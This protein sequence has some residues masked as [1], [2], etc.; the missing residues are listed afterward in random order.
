MVE[1]EESAQTVAPLHVGGRAPRQWRLLQKP[2]VESLMVSLAVVVLDVLPREKAQVVLTERDHTIETFLFD[3]P[4]ES[5]GV[6]VE[7]GTPRR[8]P[9]GRD[10]AAHQNVG[11]D[12]GV[13]GIPVVNEIARGPQET[14]NGISER[15]GHLLDPRATGVLVEPAICTRRVCSSIT[16]KNRYRLRPASVSTSTVKKSAAAR[17]VQCASKNVVPIEK[18]I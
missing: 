11:N 16:K 14:V 1:I 7:I 9:N 5:F 4:H 15:A 3:R 6:R 12:T 10:P 8:Q 2:V 17:P 13:Q 18:S